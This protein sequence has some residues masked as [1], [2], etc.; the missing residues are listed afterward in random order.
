MT[1]TTQFVLN[2][3]SLYDTN[4]SFMSNFYETIMYLHKFEKTKSRGGYIKIPYF[5]PGAYT[6]QN[7]TLMTTA[8][9][10][11]YKCKNMYIFKATHHIVMDTPY[12]GELVIEMEPIDQNAGILFACFLLRNIRNK[13]TKQ[14]SLDQLIAIS[15]NPP[16]RYNSFNFDLKSY[17]DEK[18][19]KIIY[20][21]GNDNVVVYTT[22]INIHEVKFSKYKTIPLTLF[23]PYPVDKKYKVLQMKESYVGLEGFQEGKKTKGTNKNT[24]TN[25]VMTCTPID[26]DDNEQGANTATYLMDSQTAQQMKNM[27]VA[28]AMMITIVLLMAAYLG[29][30]P[31][32]NYTI[33]QGIANSNMLIMNTFLFLFL[34]TLLSL[35]L[36]LNGSIYDAKETMTGVMFLVFIVLSILSIAN[37]RLSYP[38]LYGKPAMEFDKFTYSAAFE[39]WGKKVWQVILNHMFWNKSN[40]NTGILVWWCALLVVLVIPCIVIGIKQDKASNRQ[41]QTIRGYRNNLIGLIMGIGLIY[42][43][44]AIIYV[45]SYIK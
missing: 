6:K 14:S 34:T 29:A 8:N 43:L 35:I 28:Y 4:Q 30:P 3:E 44:I 45:F 22:P 38:E 9:T 13:H 12:D 32:F 17:F 27:G 2:D 25:E 23:A 15:E 18:Q 33:V 5:M 26:M 31:L 1:K 20:N 7:G 37:A 36:L 21:S 41:E 42:G 10:V 39:E 16:K 11:N 40:N 19:K 24:S